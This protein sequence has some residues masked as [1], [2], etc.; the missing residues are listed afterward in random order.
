MLTII[1]DSIYTEIKPLGALKNMLFVARCGGI[2][3]EIV[4]SAR[5]S[6]GRPM[7]ALD[8]HVTD[9]IRAAGYAQLVE[10]YYKC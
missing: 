5:D 6:M 4:E 9:L 3:L 1:H 10:T 7:S 2:V 8:W